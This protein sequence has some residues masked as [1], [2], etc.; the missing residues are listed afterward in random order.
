MLYIWRHANR[1]QQFQKHDAL[2]IVLR[3]LASA[4]LSATCIVSVKC[5]NV[6][7]KKKHV[8]TF[9]VSLHTVERAQLYTHVQTIGTRDIARHVAS[10]RICPHIHIL[11]MP[12]CVR[13]L[14]QVRPIMTCIA[15]FG[16]A[17]ANPSLACRYF[18]SHHRT[19]LQQ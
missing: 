16:R 9:T 18:P 14:A 4:T 7:M 11:C 13:C 19:W 3:S 2:S 8:E 5:R 1:V 6:T 12:A 17:G 10:R 15:L